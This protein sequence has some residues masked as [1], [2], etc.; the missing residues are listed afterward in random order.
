MNLTKKT[1]EEL[2]KMARELR[3]VDGF[4]FLKRDIQT[5]LKI[6]SKERWG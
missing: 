5:E 2:I 3:K 1:R 4:P 6:K